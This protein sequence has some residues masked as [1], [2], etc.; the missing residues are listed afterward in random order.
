M[1]PGEISGKRWVR[2]AEGVGTSG[3]LKIVVRRRR[4][5]LGCYDLPGGAKRRRRRP[6]AAPFVPQGKQ[7][8]GRAPLQR[9]GMNL[10]NGG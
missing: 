3:V 5:A 6:F 1:T 8:N 10:P 7:I 9:P 4:G 2:V